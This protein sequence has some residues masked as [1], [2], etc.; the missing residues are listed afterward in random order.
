LAARTA[1]ILL[2]MKGA[3]LKTIGRFLFPLIKS[4]I[5]IIQGRKRS[6]IQY[7]PDVVMLQEFSQISSIAFEFLLRKKTANTSGSV[8]MQP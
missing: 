8:S 4:L 1:V 2:C 5:V 6:K 3:K 7:I